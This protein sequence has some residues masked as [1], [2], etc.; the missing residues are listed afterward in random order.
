MTQANKTEIWLML[1]SNAD[2]ASITRL[3]T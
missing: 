3:V 1:S 2:K